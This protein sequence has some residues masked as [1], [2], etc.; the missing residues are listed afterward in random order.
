M[1]YVDNIDL[2]KEYLRKGFEFQ[3]EGNLDEARI[4]YKLSIRYNPTAEAHTHLAWL[5]SITGNY[6]EAIEECF[7]AIEIDRTFGNPYNDI[8]IYLINLERE[9]EAIDWFK[10]AIAAP[11]YTPRHIPYYHLGKIYRTKGMWKKSREMLKQ[12]LRIYP[13]YPAARKEYYSLLALSN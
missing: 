8:G 13:D 1:K 2:A 11:N 7:S 12:A 6:E 9:E 3:M 5:F 4:N 10:K